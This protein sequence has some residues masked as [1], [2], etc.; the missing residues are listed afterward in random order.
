MAVQHDLA[1]FLLVVDAHLL[2]SSLDELIGHDT[3]RGLLDT[4]PPIST[5]GERMI[6]ER[7]IEEPP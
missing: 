1:L 3:E 4:H 2:T 5:D 6:A 7:E